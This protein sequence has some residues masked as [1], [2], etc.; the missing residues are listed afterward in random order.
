MAKA[1]KQTALRK[2]YSQAKAAYR[3]AGRALA[4]ESCKSGQSAPGCKKK[5]KKK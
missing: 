2:E 3:A 4:K 1:K 5:K